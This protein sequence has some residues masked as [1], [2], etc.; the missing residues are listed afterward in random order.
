MATLASHALQRGQAAPGHN[1]P[2]A[3]VPGHVAVARMQAFGKVWR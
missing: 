2:K 3:V 1:V